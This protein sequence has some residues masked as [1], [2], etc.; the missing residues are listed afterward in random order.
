M[1]NLTDVKERL[2]RNPEP[3]E[4]TAIRE[5]ILNSF[6]KLEFV[7]EGHKY[8]LPHED[9]SKEELISVS[10]LTK[11]FEEEQDWDAIAARYALKH[12]M[13]LEEVQRKWLENNL[14]ATNSGTGAHLYGEQWYHFMLNH[15][16]DIVDVVKPQLEQGYLIPHSPKEKA[17]LNFQEDL[18]KIDSIYPVLVET[19]VYM[20]LNDKFNLKTNYAGTFDMLYATKVKNKWKLLIYDYKTNKDLYSTFNRDKGNFLQ[21]PFNDLYDEPLGHYTIQLSA[22]QLALQQLGY[23]IADRKLIWLRDDETYEK[24]SLPDVTNKIIKALS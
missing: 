8:Y 1:I 5:N 24:I 22:Y 17:I 15:P 7:E 10:A 20:G 16:E 23:E 11:M 6:N 14:L 13:T 4:V 9:G 19:R 21:K 12:G 2:K 3:P 18:F